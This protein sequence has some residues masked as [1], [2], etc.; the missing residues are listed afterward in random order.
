MMLSEKMCPGLTCETCCTMCFLCFVK[1]DRSAF[2]QYKYL[3][4]FHRFTYLEVMIQK[5][6]ELQN[7]FLMHLYSYSIIT[8]LETLLNT[9]SCTF[10]SRKAADIQCDG[11]RARE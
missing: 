6:G 8:D 10:K 4:A 2:L 3:K 1:T 5:M 11:E 7:G 9:K